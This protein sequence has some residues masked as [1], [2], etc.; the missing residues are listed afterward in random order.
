MEWKAASNII[1]AG[2]FHKHQVNFSYLSFPLLR[3]S[4]PL[5]RDGMVE[6]P[7]SPSDW[8]ENGEGTNIAVEPPVLSRGSFEVAAMGPRSGDI[9]ALESG[10]I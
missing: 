3:F 6:Y 10:E 9:G 5:P 8:V 2:G 7:L 1:S 4:F